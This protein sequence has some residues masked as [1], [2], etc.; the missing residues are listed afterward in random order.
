[1]RSIVALA[2]LSL[3]ACLDNSA[4]APGRPEPTTPITFSE[5]A[6]DGVSTVATGGTQTIT[7]ADPLAI[8]LSGDATA[9][10]EVTPISQAWPNAERGTYTVRALAAGAGAFQIDTMK[11]VAAGS[12]ASADV[13]RVSIRPAAYRLD[14]HSAF[15][16]DT[17]R[18]QVEVALFDADD[19]RLVDGS[20]AIAGTAATQTA[21][22]TASLPATAGTYTVTA[23]ADSAPA[24]TAT[25][26][27]TTA[28]DHT[29]QTTEDGRT[30]YHAYAG[31]TE[32][33]T[34]IAAVVTP[35]PA[36]TNCELA[37]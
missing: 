8:G 20:L 17:S 23:S 28:V 34:V 22:D 1:M 13:A 12:I 35:D 36:A 31:A 16:V 24:E 25:I 18:P 5:L 29:V 10:Y 4:A 11:G 9:G 26:T 30:C 15:A 27:V 33:A 37:R 2:T 7:I 6:A 32:V 3:A 19:N 21:W 14:G